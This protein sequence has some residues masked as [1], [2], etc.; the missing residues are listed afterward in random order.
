M[1]ETR[2]SPLGSLGVSGYRKGLA[3]ARL[4]EGP[5]RGTVSEQLREASLR[6][7]GGSRPYKGLKVELEERESRG[8]AGQLGR[9][10]PGA[11]EDQALRVGARWWASA[12]RFRATV[13]SWRLLVPLVPLV[14]FL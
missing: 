14:V 4:V 9:E 1:V 2:R 7:A 10:R 8:L 11:W 3:R 5:T 12:L 6:T 13:F